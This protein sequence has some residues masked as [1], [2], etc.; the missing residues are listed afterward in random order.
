[1]VKKILAN[2]VYSDKTLKGLKKEE[3]I[4]QI[5]ILEHNWTCAEEN[6]NNSV[7]NSDKI[8]YEQKA[9]IKLL[10]EERDKYKGLYETMYRQY[11]D[12]REKEFDFE[13]LKKEK[14]DYVDKSLELQKQV[15]ELE[16]L[17]AKNLDSI[18]SVQA[19]RCRFRCE[20]T[21]Q[22]VKD[23]AKEIYDYADNFFKRD[24]EM[25]VD[26]LKYAIKERYGVEVE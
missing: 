2:T 4:G 3:L 26:S 8:F 17:N 12:L 1:M 21:Q 11:A 23:T 25:F 15:D 24:E 6:F 14:N 9:E 19:W 16:E 18:E 13:A 20:L 5:R 7:K 10:T 22:A